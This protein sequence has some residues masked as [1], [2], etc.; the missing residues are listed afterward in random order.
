MAQR[1]VAVIGAGLGG[2][3]AALDLASQGHAVTVLERAATPGGKMRE[4]EAAGRRI[5]SGPTVFTMRWVLE[6]LFA[7]AGLSLDDHLTTTKLSVLA[8]HAWGEGPTLDLFADRGAS[9]DAIGAFAGP[10]E[11]Q[12]YRDFIA[13]AGAIYRTLEGSFMTAERPNPISLA[14]RVGLRGLPGLARVSPFA[15]LWGELAKH[16]RDPRLR[17]L[18]GR[19]ATYCGASPFSAPATLMLIAHVEQE[20]VW[21]VEGGM[22]RVAQAMAAAATRHGATFRYGAE[23]TA[24][25][26]ERGRASGVRLADGEVIGADAVIANADHAALRTGLF[27]ADAAAATRGKAPP[28]SLSAVT[29]SLSARASGFPLIRHTVFFSDDYEAEFDQIVRQR[30]LPDTPTAYVCAQDRGDPGDPAPD[31]P[32]RIFCLVNAPAD[33][34]SRPPSPTEISR[35]A[36]TTFAQLSRAGLSLS[37]EATV[38]TTP[39]GFEALFPATGGALY[40]RALHGWAASF[41]RPGARTRLPGLFTAGGSVHPGPGVPMATLSGRLAARAAAAWLAQGSVSI[42]GFSPAAISGGTSTA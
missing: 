42:R 4:V 27:G 16:F 8:R 28:R 31:G 33:G 7:D 25:L 30:R 39:E 26:S 17:Q 20:G 12:G 37:P 9:A 11:A 29:W 1:R 24:I 38:A 36:E 35:C 22:H 14:W 41:Q 2:L 34:D 3:A 5:D 15:T 19:Y 18:F 40:G 6:A 13:R 21:A 23:V 32:E 10:A